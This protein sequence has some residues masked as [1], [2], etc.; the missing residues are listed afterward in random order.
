[1]YVCCICVCMREINDVMMRGLLTSARRLDLGGLFMK[2]VDEMLLASY[3]M[4]VP[5]LLTRAP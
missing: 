2:K 5:G 1:M 4:S 3:R